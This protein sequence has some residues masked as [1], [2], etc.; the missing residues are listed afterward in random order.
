MGGPK[1]IAL[2]KQTDTTILDEKS[3]DIP[4]RFWILL[5]TIK[6]DII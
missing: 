5:Y 6:G 3:D 2:T 4:E 1:K